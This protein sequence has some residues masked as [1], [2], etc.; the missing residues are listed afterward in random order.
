MKHYKDG[1]HT[2]GGHKVYIQ[3]DHVLR[4]VTSDHSGLGQR[5][6]YPYIRCKTGGYDREE[7]VLAST[8]TRR[9]KSGT[10]AM[11]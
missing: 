11:F 1:W 5:P 2:L 9:I 10:L 6:L 4:G 7:K 3:N 8:F